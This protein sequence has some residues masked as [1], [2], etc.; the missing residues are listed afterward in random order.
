[1]S[2]NSHIARLPWAA[3]EAL[4]RQTIEQYT[5]SK[6]ALVAENDRKEQERVWAKI[7][8]KQG[9]YRVDDP[10]RVYFRRRRRRAS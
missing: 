10:Q 6:S 5:A 2:F 8:A 4:P 1:V 3:V 7:R 9:V